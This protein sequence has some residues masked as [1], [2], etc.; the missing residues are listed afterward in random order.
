MPYASV[1]T[2]SRQ[3]MMWKWHHLA[4]ND[5]GN[6]DPKCKTRPWWSCKWGSGDYLTPKSLLFQEEICSGDYLTPKALLFQEEIY[7]R[8]TALH[9]RR[10]QTGYD[11]L[12]ILL[13][14]NVKEH[15]VCKC[16]SIHNERHACAQS[17][18]VR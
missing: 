13:W 3:H 14:S 7:R 4:S 5:A 8:W 6:K 15:I 11:N 10:L 12:I 17:R 1:Q 9:D 16:Q 18:A 2:L